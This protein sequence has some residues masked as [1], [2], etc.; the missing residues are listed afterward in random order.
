[1][2]S[3][4]ETLQININSK[5]TG[6]RRKILQEIIE[7]EFSNKESLYHQIQQKEK[8]KL[9]KQYQVEVEFDK[10]KDNLTKLEHKQLV[11]NKEIERVKKVID[12]LG[13]D[14]NGEPNATQHYDHMA[15]CYKKNYKAIKLQKMLDA[16]E[17]NA[18]S[19]N[20][21]NKL[22]TRLQLASTL[23]EANI[24][25]RE[26]LGNGIIP[27]IRNEQITYTPE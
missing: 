7:K 19:Q 16:I 2:K 24:I 10:H 9:V 14:T 17:S 26:V 11:L 6:D 21:K 20:L 5:L 18:P 22:I 3:Q 15:G 8:E 27:S 25:M 23:G 13:L 1:M 12:S 4:L